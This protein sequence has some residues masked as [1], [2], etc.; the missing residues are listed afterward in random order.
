MMHS[1][2]VKTTNMPEV[3]FSYESSENDLETDPII[4]GH[5]MKRN[6][7]PVVEHDD[8]FVVYYLPTLKSR[9]LDTGDS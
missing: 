2:F 8:V 4:R 9:Y 5:K 3:T 6:Y 1:A 7:R